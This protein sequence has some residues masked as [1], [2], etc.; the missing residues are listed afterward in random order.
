MTKV[1]I[2]EAENKFIQNA[3]LGTP[4]QDVT[5]FKYAADGH[6]RVVVINDLEHFQALHKRIRLARLGIMNDRGRKQIGTKLMNTLA[7]RWNDAKAEDKNAAA[8]RVEH[9][10]K[11]IENLKNAKDV[12]YFV[13]RVARDNGFTLRAKAVDGKHGDGSLAKT[14][15]K[16]NAVMNM[17]IMDVTFTVTDSEYNGEE[18]KGIKDIAEAEKLATEMLADKMWKRGQKNLDKIA[19]YEAELA[20][21]QALVGEAIA[22]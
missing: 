8:N 3:I 22:A 21:A 20:Q 19:E 1:Q 6:H 9:I 2:T 14:H 15:I 12:D 10:K 11:R 4:V 18:F 7:E 16:I 17:G 13:E 5:S